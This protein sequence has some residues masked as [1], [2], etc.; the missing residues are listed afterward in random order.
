MVLLLAFIRGAAGF[1]AAPHAGTSFAITCAMLI[2]VATGFGTVDTGFEPAGTTREPTRVATLVES[3]ISEAYTPLAGDCPGKELQEQVTCPWNAYCPALCRRKCETLPGCKG[4]S[5]GGGAYNFNCILKSEVC[6][7]TTDNGL[8]FYKKPYRNMGYSKSA[9]DCSGNNIQEFDMNGSDAECAKMCDTRTDCVGYSRWGPDMFCIFKS[10]VCSETTNN[11]WT[12]HKKPFRL[13]AD[14][15]AFLK[16]MGYSSSAENLPQETDLKLS[17]MKDEDMHMLAHL[18]KS[19]S[20][21]NLKRLN[22]VSTCNAGG[23]A[24]TMPEVDGC[25]QISDSGMATLSDAIARGTLGKLTALSLTTH[26]ISDPGMVSLSEAMTS[27]SL[28]NLQS[29]DLSYN[30][31]GDAGMT[32]LAGAITRGSIASLKWLS[33]TGA[34]ITAAG[35]SAL[36]EAIASGSLGSL[37]WLYLDGRQ[38]GREWGIR[39]AGVIALANAMRNP[40]GSLG[41]LGT[42]GLS[43]NR[44]GKEGMDALHSAI[45]NGLLPALSQ[46]KN[47]DKG[48]NNVDGGCLLGECRNNDWYRVQGALCNQLVCPLGTNRLGCAACLKSAHRNYG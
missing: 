11:G 3:A 4:Y 21:E 17:N 26:K 12:F 25:N 28:R 19:G 36:A 20:L 41:K 31:I 33:L 1:G 38:Y 42:L 27:G 47:L 16:K 15:Q 46:L 9:G 39:D 6:S 45:A 18:I 34:M 37:Q 32:A 35:A 43:Y 7:K 44:I 8:T 5:Q 14:I 24:V 2:E 40:K 29:L 23:R 10:A 48:N 13:T 22:L 30:D